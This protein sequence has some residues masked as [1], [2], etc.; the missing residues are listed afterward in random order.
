MQ[1]LN[2]ILIGFIAFCATLGAA[3]GVFLYVSLIPHFGLIGDV[4]AGVVIVGLGCSVALMISFTWHKVGAWRIRRNVVVAGEVVAVQNKD[5][6][7]THLS[8][9][10]VAAGVPRML[11]APADEEP[12]VAD[13]ATIIELYK[14]GSTLQHITQATGLTYYKVQKT[15]EAAKR[16]GV[17]G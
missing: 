1:S 6:S 13:D 16:N 7:W 14:H 11:P 10:H 8:A 3:L 15:V 5:G 9:Q 2:R 12:P 4:V 17:I